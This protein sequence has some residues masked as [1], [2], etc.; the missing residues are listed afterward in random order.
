M[1]IAETLRGKLENAF[2]PTVL[3]IVDESH[4]HAGHMGARPEGETHFR[5]MIVSPAFAGA[6][7]VQ[8]HRMVHDV[9]AAELRERV[10]AL[11]LV[12]RTPDE[13]ESSTKNS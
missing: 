8:R 6:G 12:L 10:H 13:V 11:A 9:L 7:R 5:V 2:E 3:D 4:L 1:T